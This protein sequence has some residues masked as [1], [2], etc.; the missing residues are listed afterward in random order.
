MIFKNFFRA[1]FLSLVQLDFAIKN[2]FCNIAKGIRIEIMDIAFILKEY[3]HKQDGIS[4]DVFDEHTLNSVYQ[5]VLK[6]LTS[7]FEIELSVL[8][9]ISYCLYEI[10]DNVH[11]HSG[12]RLG[13]AITHYDKSENI[14]R[15]LVADDG[16]GIRESLASNEK[17]R[18]ISEAE[19]LQK[20]LQDAVTD[21]KGMGFGLYATSRMIDKIGL[22]FILHSGH[23][24]LI[25]ANGQTTVIDNG[26]WQGTILFMEITTTKDFDPNDVVDNRTDAAEEFNESFVELDALDRLW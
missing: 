17:Y 10:L 13:T 2:I 26:F 3:F 9:S 12:R 20:C 11:I 23:H 21:G 24:K 7:H 8:Q 6:N 14:L 15:V 16:V 4:I 1:Y 5:N 25:I 19:A 18:D 22:R